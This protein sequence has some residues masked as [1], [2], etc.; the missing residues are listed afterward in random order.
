MSS[1]N[2]IFCILLVEDDDEIRSI[3][4]EHLEYEGFQVSQA[5]NGQEGLD[6]ARSSRP[7][8]IVSDVGMPILD[9]FEMLKALRADD[10]LRTVPVIVHS[11]MVEKGYKEKAMSLGATAFL[12]KPCPF[13][14]I[15]DMIRSCL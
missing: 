6:K 5:S 8:L 13:N 15:L 12:N 2:Q 4:A 1:Q 3:L 11:V 7:S 14:E 10:Q 9:G